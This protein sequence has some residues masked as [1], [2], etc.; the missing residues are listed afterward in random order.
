MPSPSTMDAMPCRVALG[1]RLARPRS[2]CGRSC[3]RRSPRARGARTSRRCAGIATRP[4]LSGVISTAPA[5]NDRAA[6]RSRAPRSRA[7]RSLAA[8]RSN[9][10]DRVHGQAAVERSRHH[11]TPLELVTKPGR[12][13]DPTLRVEGVLVLP[14]EHAIRTTCVSRCGDFPPLSTTRRHLMTQSTTAST[15]C[16][17]FPPQTERG[18]PTRGG[19]VSMWFGRSRVQDRARDSDERGVTDDPSAGAAEPGDRPTSTTANAP[20]GSTRRCSQ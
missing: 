2:R 17:P 9:S 19:A 6:W 16:S 15:L 12:E 4:C 5:K 8:T 3:R 20:D 1:E 10:V 13:D 11:R 7:S 18:A 14:Q